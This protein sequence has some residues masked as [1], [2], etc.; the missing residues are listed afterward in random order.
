MQSRAHSKACDT[1]GFHHGCNGARRLPVRGLT[2][3]LRWFSL[4][5][6]RMMPE[7]NPVFFF[8]LLFPRGCTPAATKKA[9]EGQERRFPGLGFRVLNYG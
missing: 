2:L 5:L 4:Q 6:D 8:E 7:G 9:K 1:E 3:R